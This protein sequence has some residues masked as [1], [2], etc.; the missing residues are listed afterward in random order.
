MH[1]LLLLG[2]ES[3]EKKRRRQ[4]E[5]GELT[6]S[7]KKERRC[8]AQKPGGAAGCEKKKEKEKKVNLVGRGGER[9]AFLFFPPFNG[10]REGRGHGDDHNNNNVSVVKDNTMKMDSKR[11]SAASSA[12]SSAN[13]GHAMMPPPASLHESAHFANIMVEFETST[14]EMAVDV[15]DSFIGHTK[16]PPKYPPP[17]PSVVTSAN[18]AN[19]R[20][21]MANGFGNGSANSSFSS[22]PPRDH[23]R[24]EEDGHL[25]NSLAGPTPPSRGQF[26][27]PN[28]EQSARIQR[29]STELT[30]RGLDAERR[31]R[32]NEFLRQSL[33][34]SQKMNLLKE[35]PAVNVA[36]D[37]RAFEDDEA[38]K[39][40]VTEAAE[41]DR[42]L[43]AVAGHVPA[44]GQA[45]TALK[46]SKE[47]A[48]SINLFTKVRSEY[49]ICVVGGGN[50]NRG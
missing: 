22:P 19:G 20:L 30:K 40:A 15:P 17:P 8:K 28:E 3:A 31:V 29:Y 45:L 39:R 33:R 46:Q 26:A 23:L 2:L 13:N 50:T 12:R 5:E 14:R 11:S 21:S 1:T 35:Q 38:G 4:D 41:V 25:A 43:G 34:T 27:A 42:L 9:R 36:A 24:I 37:N 18:N 47:F 10:G 7:G 48:A 16:T 32:E 6:T 49:R 44:V